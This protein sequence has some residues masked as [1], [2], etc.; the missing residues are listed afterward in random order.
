MNAYCTN[1][2]IIRGTEGNIGLAPATASPGDVIAALLGCPSIMILRPAG[3]RYRVIGEAVYQGFH[4]GEGFL[5][6]LPDFVEPI[7]YSY[8][9]GISWWVFQNQDTKKFLLGDPRLGE[10]PKD[11]KKEEYDERKYFSWFVNE[12]SGERLANQ[13]PRMRPDALKE[14]GV[15][16]KVFELV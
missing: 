3:G 11:W 14:R 10:L 13:D 16:L 8:K 12:K 7:L 15:D 2:S 1:R 4:Y 6:P 9:E 5:G